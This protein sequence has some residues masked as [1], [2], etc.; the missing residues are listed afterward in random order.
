MTFYEY[1]MEF[2]NVYKDYEGKHP[3]LREAACV[4]V[5]SKYEFLPLNQELLAGRKRIMPL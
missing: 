2:T 1:I 3:A 5:M 4:A